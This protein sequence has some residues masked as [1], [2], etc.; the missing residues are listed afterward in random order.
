MSHQNFTPYADVNQ[1]LSLLLEKAKVVLEDQF[2]GMYLYGSLSSG[3]FHPKASD[4]DFLVV[5]C[6]ALPEEVILNL[7]KMHNEIWESGLRW[8]GKLEG[9]YI[10]QKSLRRYEPSA[11]AY[12]TINEAKFYV[13][14][15]GSDWIIQRHIIRK[16]GKALEGP[17][18]KSLIDPVTS[19]E[20]RKAV[21]GILNEWWF[22]MLEDPSWLKEHDS[23]YHS[24]AILTMCRAL[25]ALQHGIIVSKPVAAKWAQ[26]EFGETWRYIIEQALDQ[27]IDKGH[28]ELYKASLEMMKFTRKQ[29]TTK[30]KQETK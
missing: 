5:T 18:P 15:H 24:F 13:D 16:Y 25:H 2:L 22:P 27:R 29:I 28:Y 9:S 6:D 3:D 10:P 21:L 20:I 17:D 1:V 11:E 8:A 19:D 30:N 26:N 4:I 7:E 14:S 12:P 23:H